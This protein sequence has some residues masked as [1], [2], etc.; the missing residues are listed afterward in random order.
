MEN[1]IFLEIL[2]ISWPKS[3]HI[4]VAMAIHCQS[5]DVQDNKFKETN[6]YPPAHAPDI[7]LQ[8]PQRAGVGAVETIDHRI[9]HPLHVKHWR[10]DSR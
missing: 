4:V 2:T 7:P 10:W 9:T 6:A 8:I 3:L 5:S 1:T